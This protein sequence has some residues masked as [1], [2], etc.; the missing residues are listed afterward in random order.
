MF[1]FKEKCFCKKSLSKTVDCI[2]I[3]N[4][5]NDQLTNFIDMDIQDFCHLT[6]ISIGCVE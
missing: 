5:V 1:Y 4:V 3:Y 6:E 2:C